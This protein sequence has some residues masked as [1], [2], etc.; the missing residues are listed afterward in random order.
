MLLTSASTVGISRRSTALPSGC[1]RSSAMLRL[2]R[3]AAM[4][5]P[6]MPRLRNWPEVRQVSPVRLSTL[7]I[8]APQS[9][10]VW[11]PNG[12]NSTVVR[13]RMR[14]PFSG[15][16]GSVIAVRSLSVWRQNAGR[17]GDHQP[18]SF[19]RNPDSTSPAD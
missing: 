19:G 16:V 1:F 8:S 4:N 17:R 5:C 12:P 3:F 14:K 13:S 10:R 6:L 7:M 11:V 9:P 2:L 15:P 18:G